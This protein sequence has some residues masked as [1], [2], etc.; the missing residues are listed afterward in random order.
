MGKAVA[1]SINGCA[2][3]RTFSPL[4][5]LFD[6]MKDKT[7]GLKVRGFGTTG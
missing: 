3:P 5:F 6:S 4:V 2:K 1:V 7:S